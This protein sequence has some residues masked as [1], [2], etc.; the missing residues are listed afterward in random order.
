MNSWLC[1]SPSTPRATLI[2]AHGAGAPMD[3][4]FMAFL[5]DALAGVGIATVR[6]E[7][8]YMAQRREGGMKR[9]P[10]RQTKLLECWRDTYRKIRRHSPDAGLWIGGKS[11]GGRMATLVAEEL[12]PEG[13]CCFGFPF[14][15]PGK[16]QN[17]MRTAHF[18]EIKIPGLILQCTRDRFG[19]KDEVNDSVW[20]ANIQ[21][22]WLEEA[23]HDFKPRKSSGLTQQQIIQ[24]A[25]HQV[26]DF[27]DTTRNA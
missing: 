10:D 17:D 23:D 19:G 13:F 27:I 8:P 12:R 24:F 14:F 11:M 9:P 1:I 22:R 7:F 21:L 2:L 25:A 16:P 15:P 5:C 26:A 6:F 3:S 18:A 20:P 4:P